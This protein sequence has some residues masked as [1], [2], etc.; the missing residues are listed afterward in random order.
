MRRARAWYDEDYYY[1]SE[2]DADSQ[3]ERCIELFV[4][5]DRAFEEFIVEMDTQEQEER[6]RRQLE[7]LERD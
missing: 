4:Q 2:Y 3:E 7:V 1:R 5:E 6:V